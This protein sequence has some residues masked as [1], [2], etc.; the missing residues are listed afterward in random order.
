MKMSQWRRASRMLIPAA[1]A[2]LI[3]A[4][5]PG[6]LAQA[7]P[8]SHVNATSRSSAAQSVRS[9]LRR[10]SLSSLGHGIAQLPRGSKGPEVSRIDRAA[11]ATRSHSR[12]PDSRALAA[13][14]AAGP[15]PV[16]VARSTGVLGTGTRVK[17]SFEGLNVYQERYVAGNGNQFTFE[18]PDQGMCVGN[19]FVL[20]TINDAL[21]VFTTTGQAVTAPVDLNSFYGYPPVIDRT[22]GVFG[23]ELTDPSCLFDS[24]D[25]R[26]IHIALTLDVRRRSGALTLNNHIDIAVSRTADPTGGWEF[27]SVNATDDGRRRTPSHTD[28]PCIGDYPHIGA[29]RNGV[30][31]TTNEYPW[32]SEPGVF[33]TNFNGAQLYAFSRQAL[34]SGADRVRVVQLENLA[35]TDG[36]HPIPGFT[37]IPANSP[38]GVFA[39]AGG[40][41]EYFL[42]TAAAA[43]TGNPDGRA[44]LIGLWTLSNT[45][46]LNGNHS[47]LSLDRTTVP[48]Q[49]YVVP[50]ASEQKLGNVPLRDCLVVT[51]LEGFGPSPGETE[52]PLDSSDTR[53]FNT[54]YDGTHV[55]GSLSTAVRVAQNIQAG[56]AWF[57]V[58]PAGTIANQGYVAVAHNNVIYAGIAT[59]A[60][61]RGA[62]GV[63]LAG[64]DWYPTAAYALVDSNG[65]GVL[66]V[67]GPGAGPQDGFCEYTFFNCAGTPTPHNRPR[68]GDY[69]AAQASGNSIWIANEYI[70]QTCTFAQFQN[71][72]LCG[73]TRG[74][75]ANWSTRVS[76]IKP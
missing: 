54:W 61:G 57:A 40:G 66:H 50:P 36:N 30:Y 2:A 55:W 60:S 24:V 70:A 23:P 25:H 18:P 13:V 35:L 28:C 8:A 39:D 76:Q 17:Q 58:D 16:P 5:A 63:S 31:I 65:P 37:V 73:Q 21:R 20:E 42:S 71:D 19:G 26:W 27:Y 45:Q 32:S 34:T 11:I 47:A 7:A 72:P 12:R 29:D 9:I 49:V 59:L 67:V 3:G 43:E 33:G 69:P 68:W 52:G 10:A 62:M 22:T 14:A 38:E 41:S 1:A 51:C 64:H 46:S 74:S 4:L 15:L 56:S 75:A 44:D 48:S 6:S 53:I